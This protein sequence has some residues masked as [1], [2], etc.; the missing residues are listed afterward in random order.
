M[1]NQNSFKIPLY[2]QISA[3]SDKGAPV[4]LSLPNEH[5]ISKIYEQIALSLDKEIS[6]LSKNIASQMIPITN[7][8]TC[9]STPSATAWS[10]VNP[11]VLRNSSRRPICVKTVDAP[12]VW[13]SSQEK[14]F[15]TSRIFSL[16]GINFRQDVYPRKIEPKGNYAVYI[17]WSKRFI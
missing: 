4:V 8:L 14:L 10:F 16:S 2:Q 7:L 15:W 11:T 12:V 3:F 13:M 17:A 6:K 9:V 5:P 1:L